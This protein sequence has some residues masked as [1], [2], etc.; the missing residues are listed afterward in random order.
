MAYART[1]LAQMKELLAERVG[2]QNRFWSEAEREAAINEALAVWQLMTG[3]FTDER[4]L[5]VNWNAGI[6]HTI[7]TSDDYKPIAYTRLKIDGTLVQPASL[8]GLDKEQYTWR[9][10]TTSGTPDN[11]VAVGDDYIVL[12]PHVDTQ[13]N[14]EAKTYNFQSIK[15]DRFLV[16]DTDYI[17]VGDE[18][19]SALLDYAQFILAVK[20]GE[21]EAFTNAEALVQLFTL[22]AVRRGSWLRNSSL[23]RKF[24]AQEHDKEVPQRLSTKQTGGFRR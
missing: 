9:A 11:W 23:Y 16:A 1:T 17:Q 21:A 19:L 12:H 8:F 2:G 10:E 24:A 18:E 14:H 13:I 3:D 6:G 20:E 15:G 4:N 5:I 7:T 22:A